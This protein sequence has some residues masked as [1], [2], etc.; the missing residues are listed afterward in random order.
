MSTPELDEKLK[1]YLEREES[2]REAGHSNEALHGTI[3]RVADWTIERD[4]A[5]IARFAE[6]HSRL[7]QHGYRIGSVEKTAA[8]IEE[9]ADRL[10]EDTGN[11]RIIVAERKGEG[12][13]KVLLAIMG[14][15]LAVVGT[16]LVWALT[17]GH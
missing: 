14:A 15:A 11:H 8:K 12:P 5:D 4:K 1:A 13:V 6:V 16:L 3:T 17:R 2:E 10:A 9:K 7:D